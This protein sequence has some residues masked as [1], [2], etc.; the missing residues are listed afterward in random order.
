[1]PKL[2]RL[3]GKKVCRIAEKLGFIFDHYSG[4]HAIYKHNDG[5]VAT[6][7]VHSREEIGPGLLNDIIKNDF[8]LTRKE[9]ETIAR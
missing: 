8:K 6:I 4:S 9:F 3:T 7:P 5:R 1:M 2:P